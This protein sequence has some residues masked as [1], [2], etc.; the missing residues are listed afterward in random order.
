M[1]H[2]Y[3]TYIPGYRQYAKQETLDMSVLEEMVDTVQAAFQ[4]N[5]CKS[6][7]TASQIDHV[8]SIIHEIL[9]KCLHLYAYM[10]QMIHASGAK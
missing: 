8:K 7:Q 3:N 2:W 10:L 4:Q 9:H 5:M 6:I 1:K